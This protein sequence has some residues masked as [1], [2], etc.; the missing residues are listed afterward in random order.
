MRERTFDEA[1]AY[2]LNQIRE[3]Q[4][5]KQSKCDLIGMVIGLKLIH[6]DEIEAEKKK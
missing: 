6:Q 4:I 3:M 1:F 5:D 2:V